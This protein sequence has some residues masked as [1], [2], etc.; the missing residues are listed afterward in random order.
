MEASRDIYRPE[1]TTY[2]AE[3]RARIERE[4]ERVSELGE[5]RAHRHHRSS[6]WIKDAEDIAELELDAAEFDEMHGVLVDEIDTEE[7]GAYTE[8]NAMWSG[9]E[10]GPALKQMKPYNKAAG[11]GG[12]VAEFMKFGGKKVFDCILLLLILITQYG[13]EVYFCPVRWTRAMDWPI[14]KAGTRTDPSNY[15][16]KYYL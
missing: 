16:T 2:D 9:D 5:Q 10:L 11:E 3:H 4:L 7:R 6:A 12:I 14:Y 1:D 8:L 15:L 13:V